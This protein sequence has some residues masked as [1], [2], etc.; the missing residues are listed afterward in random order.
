[1]MKI[2]GLLIA[3][4]AGLPALAQDSTF[5]QMDTLPKSRKLTVHG[6]IKDLQTLNFDKDFSRLTSGNLL[7]NRLNL[8]WKRGEDLKAVMEL[9]TRLFWG[10]EI[11]AT[12]GFA[13][14]LRNRNDKLNLQ[15]AWIENGSVVLHSNVERLYID[16]PVKALQ[17][18]LGRQRINWGITTTWNPNDIFNVYNFLDFDYEERPGVDG[19]KI[20]YLFPNASKMEFAFAFAGKRE[21]VGALKYAFNTFNYDLQF[22]GGWYKARPTMG[23][24]WAGYIRDAGFKGEAQMFFPTRTASGH[25]N[26]VLEGDYMFDQGLY[27]NVAVLWNIRGISRSL[28]IGEQIDFD[29][30]PESLMPTKWNLMLTSAK[31]INPLFLINLGLLYAPGTDLFILFP[32]LQYNLAPDLDVNLV[33]QSFFLKMDNDFQAV[34]H[35]IYLRLKWNF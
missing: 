20:Q 15:N 18:R 23:M 26:L 25:F 35:R 32:D 6:Y 34:N 24:G 19:A 5:I 1:M 10:E 33:G 28:Q 12:P 7:H 27:G 4:L 9:R 3:L 13:S 14:L 2:L 8:N 11:K 16:L 30:S 17:F 29:L 21:S 22:L 31:E